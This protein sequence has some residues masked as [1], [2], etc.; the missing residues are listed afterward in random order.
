M[1]GN[2]K[3]VFYVLTAG[4]MVVGALCILLRF[5]S[6]EPSVVGIPITFSR[7]DTPVVTVEIEGK[8]YSLEVDLG[9]K[10][11]ISLNKTVLE[12]IIDKKVNGVAKWRDTKGRFFESPSF[13]ISHMSMGDLALKDLVVKQEDDVYIAN[14]A[15]WSE[16][17][18]PYQKSGAIGRPLLEK[19]NL[20]LDF[21][22]CKIFPCNNGK[23]VETA[24]FFLN[25]MVQVPFESG[26]KGII[27]QIESDVGLLRLALDTGTTIN[28]VRASRLEDRECKKNAHGFPVFT[29]SKFSMGGN[30]FG[31]TSL[32]LYDLSPE[33]KEIDG[34]LGMSFL[35]NHTLYIDY[36]K[37]ILYIL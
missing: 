2:L 8:L 16:L 28:I 7:S 4:C 33:L 25:Q 22:G 29:S 17:E 32:I 12:S 36:Q 20:L 30:D 19:T 9:S 3:R 5:F 1:S 23:Q 15:L 27:L 18:T 31:T 11:Q 37:K 24:G 14:G 10:F 35:K 26:P 34:L 6:V 13:L 21:P